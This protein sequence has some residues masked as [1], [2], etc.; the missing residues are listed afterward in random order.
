MKNDQKYARRA[1]CV[2]PPMVARCCP[3]KAPLSKRNSFQT[4]PHT[5]THTNASGVMVNEAAKG[6]SIF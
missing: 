6:K 3:P 2:G 5:S 1:S 4:G